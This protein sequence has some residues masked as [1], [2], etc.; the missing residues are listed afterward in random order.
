ML[1]HPA[2]FEAFTNIATLIDAV[3]QSYSPTQYRAVQQRL[4]LY[5][6][7]VDHAASTA[8]MER[9]QANH[10][11]RRMAKRKS[12][13]DESTRIA[14]EAARTQAEWQCQLFLR[15]GRQYRAVGDAIAWQLYDFRSIYLVVSPDRI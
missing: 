13:I 12:G 5:I 14:L 9:E 15:L 7:E 2:Q 6:E 11:L 4:A 1:E 3:R 10:R 8:K